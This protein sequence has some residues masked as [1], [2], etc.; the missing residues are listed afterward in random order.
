MKFIKKSERLLL[1][2]VMLGGIVCLSVYATSCTLIQAEDKVTEA[3]ELRMNG[4]A[5]TAVIL[6]S[7]II[8]DDPENAKAYYEL[9][10]AKQHMML[11][12]SRYEISE[13]IDNASKAN[14]LNPENISYA[15][16][17]AHAKFLDL[18]IDV[19][20]G[21][22]EISD[23]L[24]VSFA[25]FG[26]VLEIDECNSSV[27]VTLTEINSML[28][29]A[30]GGS[31][32]EAIKYAGKLGGCD[33][34]VALKA[35]AFLL[36]EDGNLLT[37]W[38]DAYES[39]EADALISEELGRAYLLEGDLE[40][41]RKYIEEA[42]SFNSDNTALY[43]DLGRAYMMK[44][45][46]TQDKMLGEEAV[47]VY[48]QYLDHNEDA[49]APIKAYVYRMMG[50]TTKRIIGNDALADDYM[51]KQEELDPFCSRAFGAP[52]LGLFT[53]PDDLPPMAGG[54][55]SRPF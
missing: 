21:N 54:Y 47:E 50:L 13:I 28:P 38:Q 30:I 26:K 12:G 22:E 2:F 29:P 46:E 3:Y 33:P 32:D 51:K 19:M 20:R 39:Y 7:Q 48:Q 31:R 45:M 40:N 44:A 1:F 11:G 37:Y 18:Y 43:I 17:M 23:K 5:D 10:R 8:V 4:H 53:S 36:P 35:Y 24:K 15:Y 25:S 55:Y 16:F 14:E 49:P 9:A 41:G 6:L 27:L 42:I 34:V 52:A